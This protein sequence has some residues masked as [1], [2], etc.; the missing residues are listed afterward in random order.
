MR[1]T[2][3][4]KGHLSKACQKGNRRDFYRTQMVTPRNRTS[5]LPKK[6][7][8]LEETDNTVSDD[9]TSVYYIHKIR[10]VNPLKVKMKVNNQNINFE[11]GTGSGITLISE[12]TYHEKLPN[13]ELANTKI[14]LQT[15]ANGNLNVLGKLGVT[16]H[17]KENMFT[18]FSLY[19]IAGNGVNLLARN[20]LSEVKLDW[21]ILFNPCKE[22]LNNI[23]KK[24]T[25]VKVVIYRAIWDDL[26][27]NLTNKKPLNTTKLPLH[28]KIP[29]FN[30]LNFT[31][32]H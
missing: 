22:K 24:M 20:W 28:K 30:I 1:N 17:N 2:C 4:L 10:H 7:Y 25:L 19:V 3:K 12:T 14:A 23:S 27:Q 32:N 9:G 31:K 11:V 29:F 16:V 5:P 21:A 8:N 15:Y 18:N 13:Y 26:N 6:N